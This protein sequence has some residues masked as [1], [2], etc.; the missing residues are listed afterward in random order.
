[1]TLLGYARVRRMQS[2]FIK[3]PMK[4]YGISKATV[5]RYLKEN[6]SSR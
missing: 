6:T 3:T 2:T 1:M 4:D 5:Y